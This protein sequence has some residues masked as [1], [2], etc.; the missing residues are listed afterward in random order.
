MTI[1]GSLV[2]ASLAAVATVGTAQAQSRT[3][4]PPYTAGPSWTGFYVGGGFGAGGTLRRANANPGNVATLN[5]D[6]LGGSGILAS[7][8][9]GVDYQV[10]PQGVIGLLAEGT[11]SNM[12]GS[13]SAQVPGANANVSS[14]ANLGVAILARAGVLVTPSS[15]LYATGGY[16]GQNFHTSGTAAA[17]GAFA[18]F[19]RD[20]YFNGWTV[21]GGLETMLRGGWSAKLE[22]RYSQFESKFIPTNAVT[23]QPFMH[24]ARLGLSYRFG[25]G[26]ESAEEP[27]AAGRRDWTGVYGGVAAGAGLLVN[28]LSARAGG[29]S[30]SVDNGGQGLLGSVFLGG[31]YQFDDRFL[32]GLLGDLTWPGLQSVLTAGGGG[33]SATVTSHTNMNWTLAAR[34]GWLATPSTLLYALGGYTNQSVT[35]TGYAGNGSTIFSS[36]DRLSGFTVGPG[37]EVMIAKGWSTRLEYRYSQFETRTLLSGVTMQPSTHTV[38]AGLAYR[39]GVN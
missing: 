38:R 14:Q 25:A 4:L 6:G 19:S 30:A 28:R 37:F 7:V 5:V 18:S 29:A 39:F 35:T 16:A 36:E 26:H 27:A 32:I 15:L 9:G 8:H 10:I 23:I 22:Y 24:T 20:D 3:D 12:T 34:L 17:G 31:D 33:A 1:R 13:M 2:A 11:W 21:G